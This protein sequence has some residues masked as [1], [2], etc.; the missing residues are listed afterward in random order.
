MILEVK[1]LEW[2][3]NA[4]TA[5]VMDIHEDDEQVISVA[6][7]RRLTADDLRERQ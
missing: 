5:K 2:N 7:L 4:C 1:A 6:S 3:E